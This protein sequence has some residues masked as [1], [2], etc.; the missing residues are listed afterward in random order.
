M[1]KEGRTKIKVRGGGDNCDR[2]FEGGGE[3][4]D[5]KIMYNFYDVN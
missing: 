1:C 4:G 2:A 3:D 5:V